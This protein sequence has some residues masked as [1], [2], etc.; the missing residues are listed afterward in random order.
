MICRND[1]AVTFFCVTAIILPFTTKG[2]ALS[3]PTVN[4]FASKIFNYLQISRC[5]RLQTVKSTET[6]NTIT[7]V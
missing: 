3:F 4:P 5:K 1:F 2:Y 7:I 6:S